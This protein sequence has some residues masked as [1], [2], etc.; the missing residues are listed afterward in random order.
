MQFSGS[1]GARPLSQPASTVLKA[2]LSQ[3]ASQP[4]GEFGENP[5]LTVYVS[6]REWKRQRESSVIIINH[7]LIL[8]EGPLCYRFFYF[9]DKIFGHCWKL[10]N[11]SIDIKQAT[12]L[13]ILFR[14]SQ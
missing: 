5:H 10:F 4:V 7:A 13:L 14:V 12:V 6:V 3:D 2:W 8:E 1:Q 11:E 9:N